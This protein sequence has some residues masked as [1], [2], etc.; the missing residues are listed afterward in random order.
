ML[1]IYRTLLGATLVDPHARPIARGNS[2]A[3]LACGGIGRVH[4]S[5]LRTYP[6]AVPEHGARSEKNNFLTIIFFPITIIPTLPLPFKITPSQA[7]GARGAEWEC[8]IL[9]QQ[10]N[11]IQFIEPSFRLQ[12]P[13]YPRHFRGRKSC[14]QRPATPR[15]DQSQRRKRAT[16]TTLQ[17]DTCHTAKFAPNS[18]YLLHKGQKKS[19]THKECYG[20][21]TH[22]HDQMSPSAIASKKVL[23]NRE[24]HPLEG[25]HLC[26]HDASD[27]KRS[28][29]SA[30]TPN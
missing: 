6:Y 14:N 28:P 25:M 3:P 10:P 27:Q 20:A 24:N 1:V 23:L 17:Q 12:A 18:P 5:L 2:H 13:T 30:T 8:T 9:G 16:A 29:K 22:T 21:H 7:I 11:S 15:L 4:S 19:A 26:M